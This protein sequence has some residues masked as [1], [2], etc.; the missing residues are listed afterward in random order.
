MDF[1]EAKILWPKVKEFVVKNDR[2][3]DITSSDLIEKRLAECLIYI[4]EQRRK[5]GV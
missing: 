5:Q 2:Q 4:K 1:E 3:P